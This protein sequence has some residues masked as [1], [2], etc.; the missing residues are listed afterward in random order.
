M[1]RDFL[2]SLKFIGFTAR[3]KRLSDGLLYD[4]IK[5]YK[6]SDVDIEPNW[7][8]V[9]LLLK[10]KEKLTVTEIAKELGFSHPAIIKIIK[11]MRENDYLE[12]ISDEK[13]HRKTYL[14]LS[15]KSINELPKLEENWNQIQSV[16]KEFVDEDFLLK[17]NH[18]E[19]Q[20]QELS[21]FERYINKT[22]GHE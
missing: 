22:I 11:K 2:Q 18:M 10:E 5:V 15:K 21:L 1:E 3:I 12:A 16:I 4:A 19:Q 17:L 8:L 7:H 6:N 13:D 14:Q 20:L 9:F